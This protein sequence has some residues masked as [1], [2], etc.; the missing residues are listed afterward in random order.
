MRPTP[1]AGY[2]APRGYCWAAGAGAAPAGAGEG[3]WSSITEKVAPRAALW[4]VVTG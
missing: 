3:S 1:C 2:R 4:P